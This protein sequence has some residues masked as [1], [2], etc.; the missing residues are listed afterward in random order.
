MATLILLIIPGQ[1]TLDKI[2]KLDLLEKEDQE[3]ITKI[4]TQ[5]HADKDV[6]TA[7]IPKE[8]YNTIFERSKQYPLVR[9]DDD[10]FQN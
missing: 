4:W 3:T 8:T 7:I 9:P 6:I 1:Q 2:V 5:Y 10:T